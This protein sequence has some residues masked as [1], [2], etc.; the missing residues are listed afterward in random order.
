[1]TSVTSLGGGFKK[2]RVLIKAAGSKRITL[3]EMTPMAF[4]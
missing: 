3:R 2:N 4:R 1:M